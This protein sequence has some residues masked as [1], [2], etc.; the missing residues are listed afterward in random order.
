V[1]KKSA[2]TIIELIFAIVIIAI[3]VI[4]LP[5]MNQAVSKGVDANLLQEAIFA[6]STKLN[7]A[8][9][10]HWDENSIEPTDLNG[11]ARV[12][13][14]G[15]CEN[16]ASLANFRRRPGHIIQALHRRCLDSNIAPDDGAG[17]TTNVNDLNDMVA[18]NVNLTTLNTSGQAGYKQKYKLNVNVTRG[19]N[20]GNTNNNQNIKE[21]TVSVTKSTGGKPIV[22]LKTYSANIGEIAYDKRSF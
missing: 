12:I 10:A 7:E 6:A 22:S 15:T 17:T 3:S 5:M 9:T 8:T 4:S 2:F 18:A 16:N 13:D 14:D 1:V 21:I 19:V 20:F 11:T